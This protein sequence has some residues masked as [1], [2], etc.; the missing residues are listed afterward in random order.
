[1]SE[2]IVDKKIQP[3]CVECRK[4]LL[5]KQETEKYFANEESNIENHKSTLK[6]EYIQGIGE[7]LATVF[8]LLL[9][10]LVPAYIFG[11]ILNY[12]I[13]SQTTIIIICSS[14]GILASLIILKAIFTYPNHPTYFSEPTLDA[15]EQKV[16]FERT[17]NLEEVD[18]FKVALQRD[19]LIK[20]TGIDSVDAMD[21]IEFEKFVANLLSNIGY[22][23]VQVTKSSGD[24]GV[25][26][27]AINPEGEKTAVQCKRLKSKVGNSAIQEIFLGKKLYKC[28]NG[29]VITNSYFTKPAFEAAV[30][31]G[32]ELWNRNRLLEEMRKLNPEFSWEEY[33]NSYYILP[34]GKQRIS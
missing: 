10:L 15:I 3:Y 11:S 1:M 19:Y 16:K 28:K 24:S 2:R 9:F 27:L 23:N 33:L 25:D 7:A 17:M 21:G 30:K 5:F 6:K 32:I 8:Q 29:M 4:A 13:S 22:K 34:E 20:S 18:R 14:F 26:I 12:F 31:S